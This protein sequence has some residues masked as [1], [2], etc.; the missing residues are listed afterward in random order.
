[1]RSRRMRIEPLEDRRMLATVTVGNVSDIVDGDVSSIAA[2]IANPGADGISLREAIAAANADVAAD[3]IDFSVSGTIELSQSNRQ[4]IVNR[5]VTINGPGAALLTIDAGH[6]TDNLTNTG[7]GFR[8]F[9]IN[10]GDAAAFKAV[11]ISGLTI[12]GGD[13]QA[14]F[15]GGAGVASNEN[16]TLDNVT[17]IDNAT[18]L[19]GGGVYQRFGAMTIRNSTIRDNIGPRGGGVYK[20][21]GVLIVETSTIEDNTATGFQGHGGGIHAVGAVG[22]VT[23]TISG[24]RTTGADADGGGIFATGNVTLTDTTVAGN[25]TTGFNAQGG[26]ILAQGNLTISGST[27]SANFTT[28]ENSHIAGAGAFGDLFLENSTISGNRTLGP[29][30]V[31]GGVVNDGAMRIYHSTITDNHA[32]DAGHATPGGGGVRKSSGSV[33]IQ[34]TIIAGNTTTSGVG[35][36]VRPGSASLN[37]DYTLI[38]NTSGTGITASTGS[39]NVL[40]QN[41]LLGP[42]ANNGGPTLT[43]AI[44][45]GSPAVN[46]GNPSSVAGG[47]G[48]PLNDQRGAPFVRVAGGR[49]DMGAYELPFDVAAPDATLIVDIVADEID[50][51]V[52][53]G[54]LS[55]REAI[56]IANDSAGAQNIAFDPTVFGVARI[57]QLTRG[58]MAIVDDVN[59][60]G[61]GQDL[62]TIDA[63]QQS[64]LLN[65]SGSGVDVSL[66]GLSLVNG[67]TTGN[68]ADN[69][70]DDRFNGGAIRFVSSGTLTIDVSTLRNNST[71][72]FHANGGAVFVSSLGDLQMSGSTVVNNRTAGTFAH[73][74]GISVAGDATI[75]SSAIESNS[76][77]GASPFGGGIYV[78]AIGSLNMTDSE[79]SGNRT[80]GSN[81]EGGGLAAL[82]P[83]T[84]VRTTISGNATFGGE[85]EGGGIYS[86]AALAILDST[87]ESNRTTGSG[88]E[89]GGVYQKARA[90]TVSGSTISG[91]STTSTTSNGGGVF[92]ADGSRVT[93]SDSALRG[94]FVS[95]L[96]VEGGGLFAAGTRDVWIADSTIEQNFT[97]SDGSEGGGVFATGALQLRGSVV[98][99]NYTLGVSSDGAGIFATGRLELTSSAII[100]NRTGPTSNGGGVYLEDGDAVIRFS[101]I[102]GNSSTRSGGGIFMDIGSLQVTGSSISANVAALDGGGVFQWGGEATISDSTISSNLADTGDGGGIYTTVNYTTNSEGE[103]AITNSTISANRASLHGG[104]IFIGNS[105]DVLVPQ[106]FIRSATI[107]NNT[108]GDDNSSEARGGGIWARIANANVRNTIISG[109]RTRPDGSGLNPDVLGPLDSVSAFNLIGGAALLGPLTDNGGP[110]LTH[111]LLPGSPAI[112]AGDPSFVGA[113]LFDQRGAPFARVAGGRIDIGAF[114]VQPPASAG[115]FDRSGTVDGNDFLTWQRQLGDVAS[116]YDGADANGDGVVDGADLGV[117]TAQFEPSGPP[118]PVIAPDPTEPGSFTLEI[119][120]T[121]GPDRISLASS[122]GT[123]T[124]VYTTTVANGVQTL[125]QTFDAAQF[126]RALIDGLGGDDVIDLSAFDKRA[127]VIGGLG[128]DLL[129]GGDNDDA[130]F[131]EDGRDLLVG[132]PGADVLIGDN[133][134]DIQPMPGDDLLIAGAALVPVDVVALEAALAQWAGPGDYAARVAAVE[135]TLIANHTV[136]DDEAVDFLVGEGG[137]DLFYA[138]VDTPSNNDELFDL[139]APPEVVEVTH[140]P[141]PAS[142]LVSEAIGAAFGLNGS[143]IDFVR[144]I[145][146]PELWNG[147]TRNAVTLELSIVQLHSDGEAT[148]LH[149]LTLPL[150]AATLVSLNGGLGG[151]AVIDVDTTTEDLVD[152]ATIEVTTTLRGPNVLGGL[153]ESFT[154]SVELAPTRL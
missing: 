6:G 100:G 122:G 150:S 54:D 74:G 105:D 50:G 109:N 38:G 57:I 12:T 118:E 60:D 73:G 127:S 116:P 84:L 97:M 68:N 43:H 17:I 83:A 98:R 136:V 94:N 112:N 140:P 134:P 86:S 101:A 28:G 71:A 153:P 110:T 119:V 52:A 66:E 13:V 3:T 62:L 1:M 123:V 87:I 67:R 21:S 4:L 120:G 63:Q 72:G 139:S 26:G 92:A 49:L 23:S 129:L 103:L 91:N 151:T 125:V 36:D 115:D 11:T 124:F 144:V 146:R 117:W 31:S 70:V 59:I 42:L 2:L 143:D 16:V 132:G 5:S 85:S 130:L 53:P 75:A 33:V 79:V 19:S 107:T 90:F 108:A 8:V 145:I 102:E 39:G 77:G 104:G 76:I 106:A 141:I 37:V 131:G 20:D 138:A 24:N 133:P 82:G 34:D 95:G 14:G 10:D 25:S 126:N 41:P 148:P 65:V 61:P 81:S 64:R 30:S 7:D 18:R 80:T 46:A 154:Y 128:N 89:G 58:E 113:P 35:P 88:S 44:L 69:G 29:R 9:D 142:A 152:G 47:F 147:A 93:I 56:A 99:D 27:L 22:F 48:V 121:P 149:N 78:A 111:A 40:N 32:N 45:P 15:G 51:N 96:D 135:E 114:E 137:D 55:L